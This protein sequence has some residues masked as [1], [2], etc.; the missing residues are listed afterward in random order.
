[1]ISAL[2]YSKS[3]WKPLCQRLDIYLVIIGNLLFSI[4]ALQQIEVIVTYQR[5]KF[6]GKCTDCGNATTLP[7]KPT[8]GKP[9]YCRTCFSKHMTNR[10]ESA[11]SNRESFAPKQAWARRRDNG[12]A[13]KD[14]EAISI[15]QR[16]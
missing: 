11:G 5:P 7:F 14:E 2:F 9:V 6:E 16:R 4:T 13:K 8:P 10:P 1:M 3:V 12:Q 15:F